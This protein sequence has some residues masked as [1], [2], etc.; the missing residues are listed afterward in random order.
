MSKLDY[1]AGQDH[2][3]WLGRVTEEILEPELEIVD[4]HHHL[5]IRDGA[6]Y[7]FDEL[8]ADLTS[9]HRVVSTVFAECHSMY[10]ASGPVE[11]RS[12]GET[13][14]VA[15]VAAMSASGQY[16]STRVCA[17]MFG[18][19][20]LSLG[21]RVDPILDA[22]IGAAG[23]RFRG[24]RLSCGWEASEGVRRV[25]DR[26][27]VLL[28][29]TTQAA[30]GVLADKGLS[31]DVWLYHPQLAEVAETA[32]AHPNL[33]IVLNHIGTPILGGPYKG[34]EDEVFA[35]WKNGIERVAEHDNVVMKLGAI[36]MR[37]APDADRSKPP[38]S[39]ET[40]DAWRPWIEACIEVF[41]TERCLFESNF[42]VQ[43]NWMSYAVVWNA[44][45]RIA[46]GASVADKRALFA[47][48]AQR[49][50]RLTT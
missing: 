37:R 25:A 5:W 22:H 43:K 16:S 28:E 12:L 10:R 31:L 29:D 48:T 15:G 36:P 44:F 27:G 2:E 14:F 19:V 35:D 38:G 42:P 23:G 9:G 34:R 21:E 7:L 40:A 30:I 33:V 41:G 50:Y 39:V 4:A 26:P 46:A 18:N 24:V 13:E 20:D 45:K 1:A 47:G 17:A 3:E 32:A 8:E 6:P 11:E 49:A